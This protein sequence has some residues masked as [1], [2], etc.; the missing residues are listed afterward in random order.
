VIAINLH[1]LDYLLVYA[2]IPG[3]KYRKA[4]SN[5]GLDRIAGALA[6]I[7]QKGDLMAAHL[8]ISQSVSL[9]LP[10]HILSAFIPHL[11]CGICTLLYEVWTSGRAEFLGLHYTTARTP[12]RSLQ[13]IDSSFLTFPATNRR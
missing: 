8:V 1:Y 7:E 10:P 5:D 2:G 6:H 13:V 12:L 11:S 4:V 3:N 9:L